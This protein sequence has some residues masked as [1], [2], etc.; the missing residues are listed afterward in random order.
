[1]INIIKG[2]NFSAS[3]SGLF[4][5]KSRRPYLQNAGCCTDCIGYGVILKIPP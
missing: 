2:F 3:S 4:M 1:M 5:Q